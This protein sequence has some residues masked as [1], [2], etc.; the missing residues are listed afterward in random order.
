[1]KCRICNNDKENHCYEVKEMMFGDRGVFRYFQCAM[2]HCLQIEE[3]PS[4][5]APYYPDSYYSFE[6]LA[7]RN[8]ISRYL[9]NL[10]NKYAVFNKGI[11]GKFLYSKYPNISLRS[12]SN[13][14]INLNSHVLDVGCG[15]GRLLFSLANIGFN[16]LLG[17]D[18]FNKVDIQYDNGLRINNETIHDV[19]G[20]WDLIMFHH[21][22]EHIVDQQETLKKA[23][24]ILKP[25]GTCLIRIPTVSS[26]AWKHYGTCWV[27]LDAPRHFYL[28]S[29][30]SMKILAGK[31]G[32]KVYKVTY[33]STARQFYDSEQYKM[34]FPLLDSRSYNQNPSGSLFSKAEIAAFAK[35]AEKLNMEDQGDQ[36]AFFLIK[37]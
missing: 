2:C 36:A 6:S 5:M 22:L 11:I 32:F 14:K 25:G 3:I 16:N 29:I 8:F 1:M 13:I 23:A 34:G 27:Q 31:T 10:R 19:Q 4:D 17:V 9:T 24:N 37:I 35:K 21:S 20:D 7:K 18:P 33:D 15:S 26:F 30:K 12:L 28:H